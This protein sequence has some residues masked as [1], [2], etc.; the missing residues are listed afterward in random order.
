[1]KSF[2]VWMVDY[3][4]VS[5]SRVVLGDTAAYGIQRPKI[6]PLELKAKMGKTPVLDVGTLDKIR[7]GDIKVDKDSSFIFI[8]C[9][10][11]PFPWVELQLYV[12]WIIYGLFI[13]LPWFVPY[14]VLSIFALLANFSPKISLLVPFYEFHDFHCVRS[15]KFSP[16]LPP[17][18]LQI[19]TCLRKWIISAFNFYWKF[20]NT[21]AVLNFCAKSNYFCFHCVCISLFLNSTALLDL[22]AKSSHF[23]LYLN[24]IGC[25]KISPFLTRRSIYLHFKVKSAV[26]CLTETGVTF[27]KG[28]TESFD[29]I[30]FATGYKSNVLGWL[31]VLTRDSRSSR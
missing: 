24:C 16:L 4:L 19:S 25:K 20:T 5:Y 29:A 15:C 11:M 7:S 10:N 23:H 22:S 13:Y 14:L 28:T 2:P 18:L 26:E 17:L 30:I 31:K 6:G 9:S 21:I 3:F 8:E 1:M 12:L 27:V